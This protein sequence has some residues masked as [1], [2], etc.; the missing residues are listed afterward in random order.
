M[1]REKII[2][3]MKDAMK[4]GDKAKVSALRLVNSAIK[5]ADIDARPKGVDLIGDAEILQVM[6]K[7]IKQ[8]RD[9]VEQFTAGGRPE[10]AASEQAEIAVIEAY[11][12]KQ[13]SEEDVKAAASAIIKEVGAA[14]PKDMG[15]VMAALKEKFAGQMDFSKANGIVKDLLK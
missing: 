3:D 9:S 4:A 8:R 15:K 2:A 7:M 13:M 10:L 11:M 14:G 6:A 1:L 12:P 5:S